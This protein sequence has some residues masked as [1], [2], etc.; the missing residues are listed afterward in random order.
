MSSEEIK[1]LKTFQVNEITEYH[2]YNRLSRIQKM[3]TTGRF[4]LN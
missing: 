3:H 1:Q 4:F 2:I